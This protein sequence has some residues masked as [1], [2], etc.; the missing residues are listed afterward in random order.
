MSNIIPS[1]ETTENLTPAENF[2][3]CIIP[4]NHFHATLYSNQ[5][6]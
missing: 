1:A 5:F 3:Q 6:T 4:T 2:M